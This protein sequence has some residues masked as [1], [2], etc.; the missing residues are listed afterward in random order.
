[1]LHLPW[2]KRGWVI[3]EAVL[4]PHC[5]LLWADVKI[6][7]T[8]FLEGYR[9]HVISRHWKIPVTLSPLH[10]TEATTL[11]TLHY[12]RRQELT[13]PKDRIYAS[14][15]LPTTDRAMPALQPDY[16]ENTSHLDV[17]R[18]FAV[19]YL[20]KNSDLD[21]LTFVEQ[22]DDEDTY[23][24]KSAGIRMSLRQSTKLFPYG[25]P[26]QSSLQDAM[27]LALIRTDSA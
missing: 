5:Y 4:G 3:Q 26:S 14:M 22:Q 10:Y 23:P 1:M 12:I 15:A 9:I 11:Q 7:W 6:Q 25:E 19:K 27:T 2:F 13:D 18:D 24:R 20:E 16:S 21:L 8:E 17:Y